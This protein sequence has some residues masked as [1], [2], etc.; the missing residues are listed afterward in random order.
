MY[1]F[2]YHWFYNLIFRKNTIFATD[3]MWII[4]LETPNSLGC[5]YSNFGYVCWG[6]G[7][8]PDCYEEYLGSRSK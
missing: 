6:S 5:Y 3:K 8:S 2:E 4:F 7:L 1:V